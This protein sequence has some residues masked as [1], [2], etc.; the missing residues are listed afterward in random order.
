MG[1]RKR[2]STAQSKVEKENAATNFE[3]KL[4]MVD[5]ARIDLGKKLQTGEVDLR[6]VTK[7][8]F[9]DP[10]KVADMEKT[11]SKEALDM[12][13]N[14][15]KIE[16]KGNEDVSWRLKAL[17]LCKCE[18][19]ITYCDSDQSA[20]RLL[21]ADIL[22][23]QWS[24]GLDYNPTNGHLLKWLKVLYYGDYKSTINILDGCLDPK[25]LLEKRE[26]FLNVSCVFH[27]IMGARALTAD[28][29]V[30]RCMNSKPTKKM[31]HVK[32]LLK[33]IEMGANVNVKDISGATPLHHSFTSYGNETT[34]VMVKILLKNGVD[35]NVQNRF[36]CSPLFECCLNVEN[37]QTIDAIKLLLKYGASP[38]IK[39]YDA[40]VICY[41]M[42][43]GS[44]QILQLFSAAGMKEAG[45]KRKIQKEASGGSPRMCGG[46]CGKEGLKRCT[47]CYLF[48]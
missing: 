25:K 40:G 34:L 39:E 24:T 42:A 41:R 10:K 2:L 14:I 47:G 22:R 3:E 33:L 46:G 6:E 8:L 17:S 35:P 32:I 20:F 31:E 11:R 30:Y 28:N 5:E 13:K 45:K 18:P 37:I 27:V 23:M 48:Y 29:L 43:K 7:K 12:M 16:K 9:K 4:K 15:D 26:S 1:R 36:G 21:E 19:N 44:P 38:N